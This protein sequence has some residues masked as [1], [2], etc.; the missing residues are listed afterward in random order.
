MG[1]SVSKRT[2]T[3]GEYVKSHLPKK[4]CPPE[5]IEVIKV[6]NT[7]K[8]REIIRNSDYE[9][10]V[11][12]RFD[13]GLLACVEQER[14]KHRVR[15]SEVKEFIYLIPFIEDTK[16]DIQWDFGDVLVPKTYMNGSEVIITDAEIVDIIKS[17]T[18][19]PFVYERCHYCSV[20]YVQS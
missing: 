15:V 11:G 17:I 2:V 8:I 13:I 12:F 10:P 18:K 4:N 9:N 7:E 14:E 6:E 3:W 19:R 1:S 5:I 20:T 16:D